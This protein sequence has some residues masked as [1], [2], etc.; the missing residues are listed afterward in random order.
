MADIV[1]LDDV[2][3]N[4]KTVLTVGTF[5]GVHAGHKVLVN[6]V[7][8]LAKEEDAR[9]VIVTFDPHPRDIINPGQAG[10]KLLSSLDE[11]SELL[12]DLGVDEMVVIPFDRDFSLLTSEEFVRDVIWKKIGVS[13]FV[14][15]YDHQFGRN[16]EG[17]I[18]TVEELGRELGFKTYVVSKQEV[19]DK[20]VSSTAIRNALHEDGDMEL[21]ASLLEK[22][23]ILNGTVVHGDK[24][25]KKIGFP[26]AN[27][28]PQNEK[29][30]IPKKGVYAVWVRYEE[31]YYKGM[32]NIG[33]RPTFNGD[34]ITLEVHILDFNTEIY[35]KD[36]QLQFVKRIRDEKQFNGLEELKN[37]LNKDKEEVKSVLGNSSPNIAKH[38]K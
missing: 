20:T 34:A 7:I 4:L 35:G 3:R 5:D 13:S 38:M 8:D 22:Y 37:Q 21:A 29:K 26:T 2:K 32:M 6:R 14:I 11:R 19:G 33:E 31:S 36:V 15:G 28:K 18:E 25:G 27:I 12:A 1:F 16:R 9:S 17:T 23:Y 10:I 30:V 24:R